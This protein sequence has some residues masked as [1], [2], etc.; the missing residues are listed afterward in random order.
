M[1]T[2]ITNFSIIFTPNKDVS[3]TAG[4]FFKKHNINSD[5]CH[6]KFGANYFLPL[7]RGFFLKSLPA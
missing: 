3:L 2:F 6:S 7:F 4:K 1:E 5:F